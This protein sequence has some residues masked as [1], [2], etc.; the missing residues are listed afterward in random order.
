MILGN[1][2]FSATAAQSTGMRLYDVFTTLPR[3][4]L[5]AVN[6]NQSL[7]FTH[8]LTF[9][10]E[11]NELSVGN[12]P[13]QSLSDGPH[14]SSGQLKSYLMIGVTGKAL[15]LYLSILEDSSGDQAWYSMPIVNSANT[16]IFNRLTSVFTKMA[17]GAAPW[18]QGHNEIFGNDSHS[19]L[20]SKTSPFMIRTSNS[21]ESLFNVIVSEDATNSFATVYISIPTAITGTLEQIMSYPIVSELRLLSETDIQARLTALE[22]STDINKISV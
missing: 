18:T 19:S 21:F 10:L 7:L 15:T 22:E 17:D 9:C 4:K 11:M 12:T 3:L 20:Q 6:S 8:C 16:V 13:V 14:I 2:A 5:L 1:V